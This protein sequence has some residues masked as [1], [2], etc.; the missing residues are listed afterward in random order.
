M[1]KDAVKQGVV[2]SIL[3][4][5]AVAVLA[6]GCA[7]P[8]VTSAKLYM[9]NKDWANARASLE[10]AIELYPD[11]AEAHKIFADLEV[12]SGNWE[13]AKYHFDRAAQLSPTIA[14][15]VA[16]ILE[17]YWINNYNMAWT[18]I[19]R[20]EYEAAE[21]NL[22][23]A[24]ILLPENVS[25]WLNLGFVYGQTNRIDQAMEMY[26]KVLELEPDNAEVRKNMGIMYFNQQKYEECVRHLEPIIEDYLAEAGAVSALGISFVRTDQRQ[27][28]LE[29]YNRALEL[30]ADDL[31]NQ[32]NIA[33]LY[34]QEG[35]NEN[36]E[37][38]LLK[39]IELDP[40]N[41]DA[42]RQIGFVYTDKDEYNKAFP[43][44]EKAAE[45]D[46]NNSIVWQFLGIYYVQ[47]GEIDKGQ[48]AFLRAEQ[49]RAITGA[50][51]DTTAPPPPPSL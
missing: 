30:D 50:D 7:P 8:E 19:N 11:N 3:A 26:N 38:Y 10:K 21:H 45:L 39:V 32:W 44:L 13:A 29:L 40:Y 20:G 23:I 18:M 48:A 9:R 16:R 31:D 22:I 28:A 41:A 51:P 12:T 37:P 1:E 33:Y 2:R 24:S 5:L 49:L 27:K 14:R 47:N 17:S 15:E 36:A 46:P 6:A 34:L 43:Y 4:L 35:D 42:F 25:A